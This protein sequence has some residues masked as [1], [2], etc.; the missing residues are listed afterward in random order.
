MRTSGILLLGLLCF[1]APSQDPIVL[2]VTPGFTWSPVTAPTN[3]LFIQSYSSYAGWNNPASGQPAGTYEISNAIVDRSRKVGTFSQPATVTTKLG[4][5][6]WVDSSNQPTTTD[7]CG[8]L[9]KVKC[10]NVTETLDF[11]NGSEHYYSTNHQ[12]VVSISPYSGDSATI[13]PLIVLW[14]LDVKGLRFGGRNTAVAPPPVVSP[15]AFPCANFDVCWCRVTESGETALSPPTSLTAPN[16]G[17]P[18]DVMRVLLGMAEQHPQGTL[19]YHVYVRFQPTDPWQRVPAPHCLGDPKIADDWL[20][21]WH[22]EQPMLSHLASTVVQPNPVAT[23]SSRLNDLQ[24]QLMNANGSIIV[25]AGSTYYCYCPVIDEYG[26]G[27]SKSGRRIAAADNGHWYLVQQMSLSG[28]TYWPMIVVQNQA[29]LWEGV[30]VQGVH[31]ASA[32]LAYS[33][34]SGGQGFS[35]QFNNCSFS[36][37]ATPVG[38]TA[39]MV[40]WDKCSTSS[41][42]HTASEQRYTNCSFFGDIGIWL[43]GNQTADIQFDRCWA[44]GSATND[45]RSSAVYVN[46]GNI[47]T[48]SNGFYVDSVSGVIFRTISDM[49]IDVTGIWC[50][51]GFKHFVDASSDSRVQVAL[52]KGKLNCWGTAPNLARIM[53]SQLTHKM[54]FHGTNTQGQPAGNILVVSPQYN[55]VDL[56]FDDT[57]LSEQVALYEP[58][59]AQSKTQWLTLYHWPMDPSFWNQPFPG[60]KLVVS[61]YNAPVLDT[62]VTIP[63]QSIVV[64]V[65]T[66]TAIPA[67]SST[68]PTTPVTVT[69]PAQVITVPG[70]SV[71]LPG[72]NIIFNSMTGRQNVLRPDWWSNPPGATP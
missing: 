26:G 52:Y 18:V 43:E 40:I 31:G 70:Q 54:Q 14:S 66:A 50:D 44:F 42:G 68:L 11:T 47:V 60:Y 58:T 3:A 57:P 23:P 37:V 1:L 63:A 41:G 48:W 10:I 46:T 25:P 15:D 53:E 17:T 59:L 24:M 9:W 27:N 67:G 2:P 13:Q 6:F 34:F 19:G 51:Q 28:E 20:F 22:D 64:N 21:Q 7:D 49:N 38:R 39:G 5:R 45:R 30:Q 16:F 12:P 62:K 69:V 56:R 71:K 61:T 55:C 65:P 4:G 33:D 8:L 36:C 29:S 35:N 72:K 32:G